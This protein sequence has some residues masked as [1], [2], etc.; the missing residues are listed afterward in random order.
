MRARTLVIDCATPALSLA[1]FDGAR[2]IAGHHDVIGRGHAEALVP[3]IAALMAGTRADRIAVDAGPGSFTG[4]RVGLA[5]A[6]A[7]GLAWAVPV[8]GY[9]CLSLCAAMACDDNAAEQAADPVAVVMIGGHGELFWQRFEA[10]AARP[11]APVA[12]TAISVLAS[13]LDDAVIHGSGADALIAA[14]GWGEARA[15]LPDARRF[16][17]IADV[18]ADLP[19]VALY[20]RGADALPMATPE[21]AA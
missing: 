16:P 4:I 8:N 10:G 7:L 18:A 21:R 11:L 13:H 19:P 9:G 3:A 17:L 2:L 6:R 15:L 12:S 1:L 14:R 5:A 20:G